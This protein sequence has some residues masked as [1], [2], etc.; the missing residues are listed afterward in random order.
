[1]KK[2]RMKDKEERKKC[3][4]EEILF[5]APISNTTVQLSV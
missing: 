5:K 2:S 4:K 3:N 1:V